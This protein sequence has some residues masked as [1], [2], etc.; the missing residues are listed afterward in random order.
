MNLKI[1]NTGLKELELVKINF[2]IHFD[3]TRILNVIPEG[4][5]NL[6]DD[7]IILAESSEDRWYFELKNMLRGSHCYFSILLE[8]LEE[9]KTFE[10]GVDVEL[11]ANGKIGKRS[12]GIRITKWGGKM[13]K[14]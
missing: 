10:D 6:I 8:I 13:S 5:S 2:V 7:R 3:D 11:E 4:Q 1:K 9:F 14:I 12:I